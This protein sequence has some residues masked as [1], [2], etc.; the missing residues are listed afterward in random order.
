M[1]TEAQVHPISMD[2]II[3][4]AG[5]ELVDGRMF[6]ANRE[7]IVSCGYGVVKNTY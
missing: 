3:T 2:G 6:T 7:L 5:A 1:V 4:K